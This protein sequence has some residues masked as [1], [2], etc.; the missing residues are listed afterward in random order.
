M[1]NKIEEFYH[2]NKV[3]GLINLLA[4]ITLFFSSTIFFV[5]FTLSIY[6]AFIWKSNFNIIIKILPIVFLVI[7]LGV[8]LLGS[9]YN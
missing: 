6:Y 7:I 3:L 9:V 4:T 5:I 8:M 2:K 1:S